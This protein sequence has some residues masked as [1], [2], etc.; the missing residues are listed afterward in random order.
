MVIKQLHPKAIQHCFRTQH[1]SRT[2]LEFVRR[3]VAKNARSLV[4]CLFEPDWFW[5]RAM[6]EHY[7]APGVQVTGGALTFQ[8]ARASGPGGQHVNTASTKAELRLPLAAIE[9]LGPQAQARLKRLL[10][11]RLNQDGEIVI[12]C[13]A[14]RSQ[15]RNKQ[16]CLER[17]RECVRMAL[18]PPKPRVPTRPTRASEERRKQRK[19]VRSQIKAQRSRQIDY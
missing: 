5:G 7:L 15:E 6:D 2:I 18:N 10:G 14:S 17:L 8:F 19:K 3:P 9:G 13:G 12:A 1:N 4:Q 11:K 16:E